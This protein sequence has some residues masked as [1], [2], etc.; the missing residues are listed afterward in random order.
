METDSYFSAAR[1]N[2]A[3][4]ANRSGPAPQ[5]SPDETSFADWPALRQ[6]LQHL[7]DSRSAA[8]ARARKLIADPDFPS[9]HT[10]QILAHHLAVQLTAEIDPLPT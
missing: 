8:V 10:Q 4:S 1:G 7:P 5:T 2:G 3:S 6:A 9:Q